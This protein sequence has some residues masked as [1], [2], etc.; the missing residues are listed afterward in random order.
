MSARAALMTTVT[1]WCAANACS[2]PGMLETGTKADDANVRGSR[3]GKPMSCAVSLF[4]AAR[5]MT[6][7]PQLI[8]YANAEDQKHS[9]YIFGGVRPDPESDGESDRR[10]KDDDADVADEI[11]RRPAGENGRAR[12]GQSPEPLDQALLQIFGDPYG[13]V[14]RRRM[15]RS[16]RRSPAS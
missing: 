3:I 16:A 10:E 14:H 4:G 9:R 1:G 2:Q 6:A 8:A 12:H 11:R 5:P 7:A 15:R 13:G